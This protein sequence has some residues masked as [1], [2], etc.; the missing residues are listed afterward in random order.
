MRYDIIFMDHMMP[1]PDGIETTELIRNMEGDYFKNVPIIA[2]TANAVSG[3]KALFL[4]NGMQD[5]L[6]KPVDLTKLE[7]CLKTFLP[8]EYIIPNDNG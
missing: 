1:K 7:E 2:L 4:G 6:T 8:K 3:A 5:Y